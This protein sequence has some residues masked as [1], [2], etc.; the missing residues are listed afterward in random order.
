MTRLSRLDRVDDLIS[1][2]K[3]AGQEASSGAVTGIFQGIITAPFVIVGNAGQ[4]VFG[5]S[6]DQAG[7]FS[8]EDMEM[9]IT[10]CKNDEGAWEA[11]KK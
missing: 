6:K 8:G 2:A 3:V 11:V 5:M 9:R 7:D 1:Q 10:T 4:S